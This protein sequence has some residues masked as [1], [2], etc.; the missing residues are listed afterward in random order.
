MAGGGSGVGVVVVA[1]AAAVFSAELFLPR[2]EL[3][4]FVNSFE[5]ITF[6]ADEFGFLNG[7]EVVRSDQHTL[8]G[9]STSFEDERKIVIGKRL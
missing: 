2:S 4:G 3:L 9:W 5:D 8:G 7:G 6:V 1:A